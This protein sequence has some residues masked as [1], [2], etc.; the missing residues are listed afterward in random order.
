[1]YIDKYASKQ[2]LSAYYAMF[3][4]LTMT[5]SSCRATKSGFTIHSSTGVGLVINQ[6]NHGPGVDVEQG[7]AGARIA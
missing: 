3:S 4:V 2:F 5:G 6:P 1:M 7:A